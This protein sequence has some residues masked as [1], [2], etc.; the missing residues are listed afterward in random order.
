MVGPAGPVKHTL[1]WYVGDCKDSA[2]PLQLF[3]T[4]MRRFSQADFYFCRMYMGRDKL[5]FVKKKTKLQ[6]KN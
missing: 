2:V 5:L 6:S 4:L 1:G 3:R